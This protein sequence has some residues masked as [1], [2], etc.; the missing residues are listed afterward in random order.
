MEEE[1]KKMEEEL[2]RVEKKQKIYHGAMEHAVDVAIA[3][4]ENFLNQPDA[5][6]IE[7]FQDL[8]SDMNTLKEKLQN[9]S[10][11]FHQAISK[12]GKSIDK[13]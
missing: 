11:T 7:T 10:R 8:S 12:L 1:Q 5:I 9:E 6:L 13:A 3:Q 2:R 4:V